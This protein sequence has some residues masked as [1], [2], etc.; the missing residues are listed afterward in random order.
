VLKCRRFK[1]LRRRLGKDLKK[2]SAR[3]YPRVPAKFAVEYTVGDRKVRARASTL[4]GGGLFLEGSQDLPQGLEVRMRFHPAKHLPFIEARAKVCYVVPGQGAGLEFTEISSEHHQIILRLIHHKTANQRQFPRAPLATQIQCRE[5]M[6]VAFSR[7]VSA[8]GMF[9]E[10]TV[11]CEKGAR[12][13]L[14][15][16]LNDGGPIVVAVAEVKYLVPKLGM[17]VEF[18]ELSSS[19]RQRLENYVAG[20]TSSET[21]PAAN[22]AAKR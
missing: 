6:A 13:D 3:R 17:G 15:F 20:L 18:V 12:V 14:R 11:P 1:P 10:T 7:D 16:H 2:P 19:D 9:V 21:Q 8:G 4:G 5:C 22:A